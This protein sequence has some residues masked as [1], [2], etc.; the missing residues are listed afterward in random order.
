[1][2]C[3]YPITAYRSK[4]GRSPKGGWP[5]VFNRREGYDDKIVIIP[6]GQCIGCRL[7]K[8]RQWA[9]RCVNES[10]MYTENCFIT[11]TYRDE[12][13]PETLSLIKPDLQKFWKRLRKTIKFRYYAAGEYGDINGRP[14][15]HSCIF[16]YRPNIGINNKEM[17]PVGQCEICR[18]IKKREVPLYHS[19]FLDEKWKKGIVIIGDVTFES[20][21]YVARYVMKKMTGDQKINYHGREP[22]F[23]MMSRKPGIGSTWYDKYKTDLYPRDK[24]VIRGGIQCKP[25]LYYDRKYDI[26]DPQKMRVIHYRREKLAKQ[27]G[28][29]ER[30]WERLKI[31]ETVKKIKIERLIKPL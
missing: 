21:A 20:A 28:E 29:I 17:H 5:I 10:Q 14:H 4:S 30:S 7:E 3:Y 26:I 15:Y 25:A 22:E 2:P 11:L 12:D 1:M 24:Q 18:S 16:G 6:C 9:I 8:S 31:K 13:I 19:K 23:A 27:Q